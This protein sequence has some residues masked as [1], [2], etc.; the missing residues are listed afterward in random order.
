MDLRPSIKRIATCAAVSLGLA[1]LVPSAALAS[2]VEPLF[3]HA[4]DDYSDYQGQTTC[5]DEVT[6]GLAAFR[7]LVM[8][9][10]PDTGNGPAL[11]PCDEGGQSEHKDGRAWDWMIAPDQH[12]EAADMIAWLLAPDSYGNANAMIRRLGVMYIIW[13]RQIWRA[14]DPGKGWQPYDG[15]DPHTTHVH[16]S[17]GWDGA[18]EKTSWYTGQDDGRQ[19]DQAGFSASWRDPARLDV[20]RRGAD[21]DVEQRTWTGTWSGWS[22]IGGAVS[23][24]P[25]LTW[26]PDGSLWVFALSPDDTL[27]FR[28]YTA[29]KGWSGWK[30]NGRTLGS[31]PGVTAQGKSLDVFARDADGSLVQRTWR[32]GGAHRGWSRW[33]DLGGEI[34]A[35]P[36]AVWRSD[37][38]LDVFVRGSTGLLYETSSESRG[39]WSTWL[40]LGGTVMSGPAVA[41]RVTGQEDLFVRGNKGDVGTRHFDGSWAGSWSSLGGFASSGPGATTLG[42]DRIDVFMREVDGAL[43]QNTYRPGSGWTGWLNP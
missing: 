4:I 16:F 5:A 31:A 19:L 34:T 39:A 29:A 37:E 8:A 32:R 3:V 6:P 33:Q 12:A 25:A 7:A 24:R 9:A 30:S 43:G 41:S 21:G 40:N 14:Y 10:Y 35:P 27:V 36:A 42:A 18:D 22:S 11:R 13:N 26:A 17:L 20:V 28:R 38:V 15:A 1:V 23:S 2:P